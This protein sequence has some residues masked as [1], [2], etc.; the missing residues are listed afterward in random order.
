MI[1]SEHKAVLAQLEP[2]ASDMSCNTASST[3]CRLRRSSGASAECSAMAPARIRTP[4]EPAEVLLAGQPRPP[5]HVP[6][7]GLHDIERKRE[8][9]A[10][11]HSFGNPR[12]PS[13]RA[14]V[15]SA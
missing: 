12:H 13:Q 3:H 10:A 2:L 11:P 9:P 14:P 6:R 5:F 8:N 4:E 7:R 1:A 15:R